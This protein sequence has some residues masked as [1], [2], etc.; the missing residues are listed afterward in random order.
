MKTN[1]KNKVDTLP[2][3]ERKLKVTNVTDYKTC[4][5]RF[6]V[7]FKLI[8]RGLIVLGLSLLLAKCSLT[9]K[10]LISDI[11]INVL[12]ED[13]SYFANYSLGRV[14]ICKYSDFEH[15]KKKVDGND[16]LVIDKRDG[17]NPNMCIY[18][19]CEIRNPEVIEEVLFILEEYEKEYPSDW[20]RTINSMYNEWIIH[21]LCY[22]FNIKTESTAHVDLDNADENVFNFPL[23]YS[24]RR[25]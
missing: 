24:L 10:G 19:S 8:K 18:N 9:K 12:E 11:S 22:E 4:N 7:D 23:L 16:I 15:Y 17:D 13:I 6:N 5:K 25:R 3:D 1:K 14:Y 20:D 2:N 21:N